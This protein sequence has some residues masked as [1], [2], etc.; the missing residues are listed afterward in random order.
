MILA[1]RVLVTYKD[2]GIKELG[3]LSFYHR[4]MEFADETWWVPTLIAQLIQFPI[5]VIFLCP[6]LGT[7]V[8]YYVF[9]KASKALI[10][11]EIKN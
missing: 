6:V 3:L 5:Y 9:R 2:L 10:S 4:V 7:A 1:L 8:Q 11:C